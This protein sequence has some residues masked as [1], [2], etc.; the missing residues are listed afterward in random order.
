MKQ[1]K[2]YLAYILCVTILIMSTVLIT[3]DT[4]CAQFTEEENNNLKIPDDAIF[5]NGHYYMLYQDSLAWNEANLYCQQMGGHLLTVTSQDEQD[6]INS[7]LSANTN[8][9]NLYWIGLEEKVGEGWSWVTQEDYEYENWAIGEPNNDFS[10]TESVVQICG[11]DHNSFLA[12]QW[13]DSRYD[14]G[15]AS[16]WR[17]S[18]TGFICE[19]EGEIGTPTSKPTVNFQLGKDN[20]SF[21]HCRANSKVTDKNQFY[22]DTDATYKTESNYLKAISSGPYEYLGLLRQSWSHWNGSCYGISLG[23]LL[24]KA[25]KVELDLFGVESFYDIKPYTNIAA[26]KYLNFLYLSQC[27]SKYN[28]GKMTAAVTKKDGTGNYTKK[29]FFE[30]FINAVKN[31]EKDGVPVILLYA[32]PGD[33]HAIIATSVQEESDRYLVTMY[34]MNTVHSNSSEPKGQVS[35]MTVGKDYSDF[36]FKDGNGVNIGSEYLELRYLD[37]SKLLEA[38]FGNTSRSIRN[39]ENDIVNDIDDETT[40]ILN[41]NTKIINSNGNILNYVNG[42]VSGDIEIS[43][44]SP[45]YRS[46]QDEEEGTL[47][48]L[49]QMPVSESYTIEPQEE[50]VDV[51]LYDENRFIAVNGND[52]ESITTDADNAKVEGNNADYNISL[53]ANNDNCSLYQLAITSN[54]A[55]YNYE[56]DKLSI[57]SETGMSNIIVSA[58]RDMD[59]TGK[60]S[61]SITANEIEIVPNENEIDKVNIIASNKDGDSEI[62]TLTMEQP[63]EEEEVEPVST[64]SPTSSSKPVVMPTTSPKLVSKTA[65]PSYRK[66]T[67]QKV[68]KPGKVTGV[69]LYARKGAKIKV[70]WANFYS[71]TTGY[72]IQYALNKGFTKNKKTKNVVGYLKW[73]KTI[74]G[75]KKGK[76]YYVKVRAYN[77]KAGKKVYGKW[78]KVKKIKIKK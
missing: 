33:S 37:T 7:C 49:V 13:N 27:S 15:A 59:Y 63:Q 65:T 48:Y 73:H 14:G 42:E 69:Y 19:W 25:N 2:K 21:S 57:S 11:K 61:V 3:K 55:S 41:D 68:K 22:C 38:P 78:S 29:Q 51:T 75:L 54:D 4:A 32:A 50:R 44:S 24:N 9:K 12:G 67:S 64:P 8:L 60:E 52:V 6:F 76:T 20:N 40:I 35:L 28:D 18:N 36:I 23:M 5:Y 74:K 34:D 26:R 16:F 46:M 10:G 31:G 77:K 56:G 53:P 47:D 30:K 72:Q 58:Y 17:L 1:V 70:E 71:N 43:N 45:I 39:F 62:T 66:T